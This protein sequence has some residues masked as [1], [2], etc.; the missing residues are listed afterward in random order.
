MIASA[1][2]KNETVPALV[3]LSKPALQPG[4]R[5]HVIP[6]LAASEQ[7][8]LD[9][10][11]DPTFYVWEWVGRRSQPYSRRQ[12]FRPDA[13]R[14]FWVRVTLSRRTTNMRI[15]PENCKVGFLTIRVSR[16]DG[17]QKPALD[18]Q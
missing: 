6:T 14:V 10:D 17:V 15:C 18:A 4:P 8:H 7:D 1:P 3:L 13:S 16:V 12:F 9:P 11:Y 5:S 2:S